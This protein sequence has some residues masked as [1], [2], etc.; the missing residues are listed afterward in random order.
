MRLNLNSAEE[1]DI[2]EECKNG[3]KVIYAKNIALRRM[4]CE[5][6]QRGTEY[7]FVARVASFADEDGIGASERF[8]PRFADRAA[9][10]DAGMFETPETRR[11]RQPSVVL[12][13]VVVVVFVVFVVVVRGH[14]GQLSA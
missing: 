12:V 5:R 14:R 3:V 9:G 1:S 11:G 6:E 4:S 8:Q 13:V 2:K 7:I 10:T